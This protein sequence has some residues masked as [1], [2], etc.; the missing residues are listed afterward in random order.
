MRLERNVRPSPHSTDESIT[1]SRPTTIAVSR[2]RHKAGADRK[3]KNRTLLPEKIYPHLEQRTLEDA[4]GN[5]KPWEVATPPQ[6]RALRLSK[7]AEH[8]GQVSNPFIE[9]L[10]LELSGG[11]AVRLDEWLGLN[12]DL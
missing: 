3:P 1:I 5:V 12:A 8:F 6:T 9:R 11:V 10:T 2:T 4:A 7:F